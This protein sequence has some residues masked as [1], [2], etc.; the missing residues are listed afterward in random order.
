[1][2]RILVDSMCC[3]R[4]T[5]SLLVAPAADCYVFPTMMSPIH[6]V[7]LD[8]HSTWNSVVLS[9]WLDCRSNSRSQ[10]CC[11]HRC[12]LRIFPIFVRAENWMQYAYISLN[13]IYCNFSIALG[14]KT[15]WVESKQYKYDF[16]F[17]IFRKENRYINK[18]LDIFNWMLDCCSESLNR[19]WFLERISLVVVHR[20]TSI[21]YILYTY[22][23]CWWWHVWVGGIILFDCNVT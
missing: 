19:T 2:R 21:I 7:H 9:D 8:R 14:R 18:M 13:V 15:E 10:L 23:Y 12:Q 3:C 1:M 22:K 17:L 11:Q 5:G 20:F 6:L 4:V 16:M